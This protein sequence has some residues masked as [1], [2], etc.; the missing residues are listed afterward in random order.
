MTHSELQAIRKVLM[1]DVSEAAK[2]IGK[3]STRTWQ[4]W[5]S[6]A[7]PIPDDVVSIMKELIIKRGQSINAYLEN[8]SLIKHYYH[9]YSSYKEANLNATVIDWRL[10]Q[11]IYTFFLCRKT[12]IVL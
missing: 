1:L 2:F 10:H 4:Y 11:S 3:V 6:G 12:S 7:K 9:E 5:E 8:N